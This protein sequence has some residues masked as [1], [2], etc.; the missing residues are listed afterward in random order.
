MDISRVRQR[1]RQMH[2]EQSRMLGLL[3]ASRPFV[4]GSFYLLARRCGRENCRCRKGK[5]LHKTYVLTYKEGG[6]SKLEYLKGE[7]IE[8]L[9]GLVWK[10][11]RFREG[12]A[13]FARV[14]RKIMDGLH[15]IEKY[16]DREGEKK[17][18]YGSGGI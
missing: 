17:R 16:L 7:D 3:L 10:W 13:E 4:K 11:K 14:H 12:R 8:V 6:E 9:R 5:E 2:T 1:V 15:Q 18:R